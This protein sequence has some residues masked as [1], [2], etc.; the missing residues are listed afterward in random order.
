MDLVEFTIARKAHV[1]TCS[2]YSIWLIADR[3]AFLNA[4]FLWYRTLLRLILN[5]SFALTSTPFCKLCLSYCST[6]RTK[7]IV[8]R[9]FRFIIEIQNFIPALFAINI[10]LLVVLNIRDGR[11]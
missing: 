1:N 9:R 5:G 10:Y 8:S 2:R 7:N 6:P 4:F 3:T 11:V